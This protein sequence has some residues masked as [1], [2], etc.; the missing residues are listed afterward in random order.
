MM[1]YHEQSMLGGTIYIWGEL[2]IYIQIFQYVG[3]SFT[4][5]RI[6]IHWTH[7]IQPFLQ[8][9]GEALQPGS[10]VA[11]QPVSSKPWLKR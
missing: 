1:N 7:D 8:P 6:D 11:E 2:Y 5:F 10:T 3:G 9:R 4:G